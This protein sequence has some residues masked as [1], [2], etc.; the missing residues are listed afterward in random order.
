MKKAEFYELVL[1]LNKVL[2]SVKPNHFDDYTS[3]M[4]SVVNNVHDYLVKFGKKHIEDLD[5]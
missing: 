2:L 4:C 1:E 5:S 3:T